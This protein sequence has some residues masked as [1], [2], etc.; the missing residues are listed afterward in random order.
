MTITLCVLAFGFTFSVTFLARLTYNVL[1]KPATVW[2][3]AGL[4]LLVRQRPDL[5]TYRP[6]P[7][8]LLHLN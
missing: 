2:M 5:G 1:K 3:D 6:D 4:E 7:S 8:Q